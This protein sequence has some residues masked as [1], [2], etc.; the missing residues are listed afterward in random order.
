MND[1][2]KE[3]RKEV[4]KWKNNRNNLETAYR[5]VQATI[6]SGRRYRCSSA[7]LGFNFIY[8]GISLM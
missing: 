1:F 4:T 3:K 5:L 8:T 7:F 6:I 2:Q